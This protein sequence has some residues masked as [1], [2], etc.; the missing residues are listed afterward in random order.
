LDQWLLFVV[1]LLSVFGL[2]VMTSASISYADANTG[3]PLYHFYRQLIYLLLSVSAAMIAFMIPTGFWY[4]QGWVM[5]FIGF[6][7]LLL[8]VIPGIGKEV[9][10]SR[11]WLPLGLFNLQSSEFAKFCILV[12]MAGYLVRRHDEVRSQWSGFMKPMLVLA[13]AIVLL[14]LEP[15]FG[16]VVVLVTACLGMIFLGG[17]RISQFLTIIFS[18][19]V[20]VALMAVSS[21]YRLQRLSCFADPW[22]QPF[23]CG[24]Q[25]I[26]S[27]I[28]FGRG[29]WLGTGLGKSVQK[30]FYLPEAHT[31]FVFAILAEEL[32]IIGAFCVIVLFAALIWRI[33]GI[34]R[35]AELKDFYFAAYL[36]YGIALVFCAQ[37]FINIGVNTG[38][39]PTKGLTL[40]FLSYGGSSLIVCGVFIG[41][42]QRI[43]CEINQ[44]TTSRLVRV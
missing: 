25:L 31:D 39:L 36:C 32:G 44:T 15:D 17:V 10:G 35:D 26:Q 13:G 29:E 2:I 12:Y 28:A 41:V 5:L 4:R 16:A 20:A 34:A 9:N 14:L 27:L 33:L 22:A 37:I 23:D 3:A 43:Y 19:L 42:I 7:L 38:L 30:L 40:P 21:S 18:S 11:R 8:V 24:Y 1:L 6:L